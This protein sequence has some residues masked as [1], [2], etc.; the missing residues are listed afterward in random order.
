MITIWLIQFTYQKMDGLLQPMIAGAVGREV[1]G[2]S[3]GIIVVALLV[4]G[5]ASS[6]LVL[7]TPGNLIERNEPRGGLHA[8]H[9][10]ASV[11]LARAGSNDRDPVH[12]LEFW[13]S[14]AIYCD[15][16][17]NPADLNG[18]WQAR[19]LGGQG[20]SARHP[21]SGSLISKPPSEK[22]AV[23]PVS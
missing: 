9:A 13:R 18:Y 1:S 15:R 12:R 6:A 5:A 19:N 21:R 4:V 16:R 2:L 7:R 20:C 17:S 22:F 10:D 3:F 14:D 8:L 11:G 23:E